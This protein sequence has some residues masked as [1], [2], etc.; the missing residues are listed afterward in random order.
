MGLACW[1]GAK[2]GAQKTSLQVSKNS[3]RPRRGHARHLRLS[4]CNAKFLL[5]CKGFAGRGHSRAPRH[6]SDEPA[7][8]PN[9]SG[10]ADCRDVICLQL[11]AEVHQLQ[12]RVGRAVQ[13][14]EALGAQT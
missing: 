5:S 1:G 8:K 4:H 14:P 3:G 13:E 9:Y 2:S 7:T 6:P 11:E 10:Q 12:R